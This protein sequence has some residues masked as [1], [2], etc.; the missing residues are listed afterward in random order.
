MIKTTGPW[1]HSGAYT[2]LEGIVRHHLNPAEAIENYDFS[3][4][5]PLVEAEN[6][7]EDTQEALDKL[8]ENRETGVP[9]VQDVELTDSQV[10]DL[11]SFFQFSD[12]SL[13]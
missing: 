5:S 8:L 9:T 10:N 12:R 2:S 4:L 6:T 3:Q 13:R 7:L 1:G 11:L